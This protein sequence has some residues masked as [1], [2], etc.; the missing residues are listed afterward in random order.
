MKKRNGEKPVHLPGG[1]VQLVRKQLRRIDSGLVHRFPL[2]VAVADRNA[3]LRADFPG[4]LHIP[5]HDPGILQLAGSFC[6]FKDCF[7]LQM[8]ADFRAHHVGR[9]EKRFNPRFLETVED[10]AQRVPVCGKTVQTSPGIVQAVAYHRQIGV[11]RYR[12]RSPRSEC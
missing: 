2:C 4:C 11:M 3:V 8:A 9:H 12:R 1:M 7:V 6:H 5:V 10:L